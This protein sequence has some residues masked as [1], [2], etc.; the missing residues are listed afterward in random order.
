MGDVIVTVY[1]GAARDHR[2]E[3]EIGGNRILLEWDDHRYLLDFGLR[4]K[5]L[6]RYYEEFVQPRRAVGIRDHLRMG[7]LPPLE[8]LYR[9][10]LCAHEPELW[11]R[12]RAHP[13]YRRLDG[14]D[15]VLVSHAHLDH[16]GCLGYLRE[17]VPVYT[18][19]TTAVIAK[20]M[21]DV[22]G[23]GPDNELCYVAPREASDGV[24]SSVRGAPRYQR[25]HIVCEDVELDSELKAFWCSV[26]GPRT[27][28]DPCPLEVWEGVEGLRFWRVD[29]SIP[30]SGAFGVE[31]PIGWVIYTGDVRRHGHSSWR[32]ER[33]VEEA[34]A[35]KPALLVVE[36]TRVD[37][38][39]ATEESE[40]QDAVD[41]LVGRTD[42]LVVADFAARNIERLRTFH[43]VAESHGRRLV[44]TEQDAY[45]LE[46]LHRVDENIPDPGWGSVTILRKPRGSEGI[47]M[48]E[49]FDR[50]ASEV[51]EA[52][53]VRRDP[54]GYVMC[55][56]YWDITTLV[57]LEPSGGTYVY[58]AAEAFTEE[59]AID[60][61]RLCNWLDHFGLE[62]YGGIP[63]AEE[64]PYHASGHADGPTI[65]AMVDEIGA[66]RILPV[67]TENLGWFTERWPEQVIVAPY[68]EPVRVG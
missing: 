53:D 20:A 10:D 23:S 25:R 21:T 5:A 14:V 64:G 43:D 24:L 65:E 9:D 40:I 33:F 4:F 44:V 63:G 68:G 52:E 54:G 34:K 67:H 28:I 45:L 26:P 46:Q 62:R 35:L 27:E 15:G 31:T 50:Y 8:G 47:W 55:L 29:H 12:Y 30:G 56:S 48:R 7:L 58:S 38:E 49:L 42:G 2:D 3:G 61:E 6:G 19:L 1:G 39:G 66:E 59:M 51:V 16:N 17:D 57:D 36:G 11:E 41:D 32:T 18:G 22:K 13:V 37:G 60:Q